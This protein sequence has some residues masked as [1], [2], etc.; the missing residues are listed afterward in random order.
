MSN[1]W[2]RTFGILMG[3]V[4]AECLLYGLVA[5]IAWDL[6]WIVDTSSA[7]RFILL[8]VGIAFGI[9]GAAAGDE[10]VQGMRAKNDRATYRR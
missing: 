8:L 6:A 10:S 4:L 5:F 3:I 7:E 1:C 9:I 2:W